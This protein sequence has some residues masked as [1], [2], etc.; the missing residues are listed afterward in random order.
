MMRQ[1][2]YISDVARSFGQIDM[3]D[4]LEASAR[5]NAAAEITGF[6]LFDGRHFLQYV[7]GPEAALQSLML[8]L[9]NDV[10]HC[11]ISILEDLPLDSRNCPKWSMKRLLPG[12][13]EELRAMIPRSLP[14]A[15]RRKAT[16][17]A[18]GR[19]AA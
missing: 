5:N 4:L 15:I 13:S 3:V 7:E 18:E 14:F 10:R 2:M 19:A 6:L 11:N 12:N 16:G 1:Y 17:F 9:G 8:R